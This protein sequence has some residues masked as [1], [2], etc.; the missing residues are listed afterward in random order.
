VDDGAILAEVMVQLAEQS[1]SDLMFK[2]SN[3]ATIDP[4]CEEDAER[5]WYIVF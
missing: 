3:P 5:R 4:A 2:G 1:T